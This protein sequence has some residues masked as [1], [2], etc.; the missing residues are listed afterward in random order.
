MIKGQRGLDIDIDVCTNLI[1]YLVVFFA[2]RGIWLSS[3]AR[4]ILLAMPAAP[5]ILK[6]T[7]AK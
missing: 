2:M 5:L 7:H 6:R 4:H 1:T 3:R